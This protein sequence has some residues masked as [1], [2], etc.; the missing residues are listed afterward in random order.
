MSSTLNTETTI[1]HYITLA[2]GRD[3]SNYIFTIGGSPVTPVLDG[4]R[5]CIRITDISAAD[6]D[7]T[8]TFQIINTNPFGM[9]TATYNVMN[10]V[11]AMF[12]ACKD[13]PAYTDLCNLLKAIYLYNDAANTY[14]GK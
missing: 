8:F 1:K 9:Y 14:F 6:L 12:N 3:I 13:N 7:G 5:Y 4:D 10:Y 11:E 2:E